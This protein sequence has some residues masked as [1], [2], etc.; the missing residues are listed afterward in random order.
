M[1]ATFVLRDETALASLFSDQEQLGPEPQ[2]TALYSEPSDINLLSHEPAQVSLTATFAEPVSENDDLDEAEEHDAN[3]LEAQT[4]VCSVSPEPV[5]HDGSENTRKSPP[6]PSSS[7]ARAWIPKRNTRTERPLVQQQTLNAPAPRRKIAH[8]ADVEPPARVYARVPE[9]KAKQLPRAKTS[10]R[11]GPPE[12][13]RHQQHSKRKHAKEEV[14]PDQAALAQPKPQQI[15]PSSWRIHSKPKSKVRKQAGT[16]P[17]IDMT[18]VD[19]ARHHEAAEAVDRP[20]KREKRGYSSLPAAARVAAQP[21]QPRNPR[22]T[23]WG[24]ELPKVGPVHV[25]PAPYFLIQAD[26]AKSEEKQILQ[27]ERNPRVHEQKAPGAQ[28]TVTLPHDADDVIFVRLPDG[29]IAI[30]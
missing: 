19:A 29:D 6:L 17:S 26:A 13:G 5:L 23:R 27:S 7:E 8:V 3:S 30:T 9:A 24:G 12:H 22:A 1:A 15:T 18:H 4:E 16:T 11:S 28:G 10:S 21:S 20:I 14:V 2:P 25:A